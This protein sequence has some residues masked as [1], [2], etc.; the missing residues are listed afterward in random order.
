MKLY[1]YFR[2]TASYRVRIALNLKGIEFDS[3]PIHLL[4]QGGEQFLPDYVAL[5]PQALVPSLEIEGGEGILTQ[6]LAIIDYLEDIYPSPSF[7]PKTP[8][9][10]AKMKSI[11]LTIASDI[12]PLN[13]LRVLKYLTQILNI[14]EEAKNTWYQH[15][16]A[17]GFKALETTL[18]TLKRDKP[19]CL[20]DSPTIADICLIPQ[21]YNAHRFNCDMGPYPI[22]ESI[23]AY[24]LT[25]PA[26]DKAKPVAPS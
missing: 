17:L 11:A 15:W 4:N 14:T 22:I 3:V 12:H 24:C 23:N 7:Y 1:D 25:L 6:S 5:N 18:S 16:I 2:S 10:K 26:F 8:L 9:L 20:G 13:N 21:V 19:V